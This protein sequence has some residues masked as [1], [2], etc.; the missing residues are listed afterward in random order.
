MIV[1]DPRLATASDRHVRVYGR[2]QR[3][4]TAVEFAAAI[5]FVVGSAFFFSAALTPAADWLFL[6]GSLLFAARPTV[7]VLRENHL[8][9]IPMPGDAKQ[10]APSG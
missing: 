10:H 9:R 7:R 4:Y 2:Y 3:I 1:F 6:V 5:A 8:A